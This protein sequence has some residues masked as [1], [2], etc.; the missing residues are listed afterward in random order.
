MLG[1]RPI[2]KQEPK[3][4]Q[5]QPP[6][7]TRRHSTEGMSP[8]LPVIYEHRGNNSGDSSIDRECAADTHSHHSRSS[9]DGTSTNPSLDGF[10]QNVVWP[11]LHSPSWPPRDDEPLIRRWNEYGAIETHHFDSFFSNC[12]HGDSQHHQTHPRRMDS[13][14]T[15]AHSNRRE[16]LHHNLNICRREDVHP[17]FNLFDSLNYSGDSGSNG[18]DRDGSYSFL[19]NSSFHRRHRVHTSVLRIWQTLSVLVM[20]VFCSS[21]FLMP[22]ILEQSNDGQWGGKVHGQYDHHDVKTN[23]AE[24]T[25]SNEDTKKRD[26]KEDEWSGFQPWK[27]LFGA[28]SGN[29]D[30]KNETEPNEMNSTQGNYSGAPTASSV[31]VDTTSTSAPKEP[32]EPKADQ[33][34]EMAAYL[35]NVTF[36]SLAELMLPQHLQTT[37]D[38]CK[39]TIIPYHD[40]DEKPSKSKKRAGLYNNNQNNS[41]D[42]SAATTSVQPSQVFKLRKQL[43]KTRDMI[44][45]FAPTYPPTTESKYH[46]GDLNFETRDIMYAKDNMDLILEQD[47]SF[48]KNSKVKDGEEDYRVVGRHDMFQHSHNHVKHRSYRLAK[49]KRSKQ[50]DKGKDLWRTIRKYLDEGYTVIGDF[51]DLDHAKIKYTADQ[52][53]G[54]Q[55]EVWKWHV[56]F[57]T[58][59]HRNYLIVMRYLSHPCPE[60]AED[61][62]NSRSDKKHHHGDRRRLSH[63]K[64]HHSKS[65]NSKKSKKHSEDS[66]KTPPKAIC[67]YIHPHTSHLF[68]GGATKD[69]LPIGDATL[70]HVALGQLGIRQLSRAQ[71]YLNMLWK[72]D[73]II[74]TA[75]VNEPIMKEGATKNK[76]PSTT[77]KEDKDV[78]DDI[79]SVLNSP[80]EEPTDTF[81]VHEVYHNLRKEVRSFL[82]EVN[83][84]GTLILPDTVVRPEALKL[85]AKK[86]RS[87]EEATEGSILSLDVLTSEEGG[88]DA[89]S[90]DVP[91]LNI[92]VPAKQD[93]GPQLTPPLKQ[94]SEPPPHTSIIDKL[95]MNARQRTFDALSALEQTTSLLGKLN[96]HYVA[97]ENY[98]KSDSHHGDQVRLM[99]TIQ[100][101]WN[102]FRWWAGR[103]KLNDQIEY[104]KSRMAIA[105]PINESR[106]EV[107]IQVPKH[108]GD[109][110]AEGYSE[111]DSAQEAVDVDADSAGSQS[112]ESNVA[113]QDT[114]A[115]E[116][117]Q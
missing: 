21:L 117:G 22:S 69:Q 101:E 6:A 45:V 48:H 97:Y 82:D 95:T 107:G 25:N 63:K 86:R 79:S 73:Y 76:H 92:T 104:L 56:D 84:F 11:P 9:S 58:F 35:A 38:L 105:E 93:I 68:W 78:A 27:Y 113:S 70:A 36:A 3:Q 14:A 66:P 17:N 116:S 88:P 61:E 109:E 18:G 99:D 72:K 10:G 59:M 89:N 26:D 112:E 94:N 31:S 8:P 67:Q 7:P 1:F 65:K 15:E 75:D 43:L 53:A 100:T 64:H 34:E 108:E 12:M 81:D 87:N 47:G 96:D 51:Q 28:D 19:N 40:P 98:V 20:V 114:N 103:I 115:G 39:S 33:E 49:T 90:T 29:Q 52:L 30:D 13:D 44:D 102:S 106:D 54:H 91:P 23:K 110:S 57:M 71:D 2:R 42:L 111:N 41:L 16:D 32:K 55:K 46:E 77:K 4:P 24:H 74:P 83:F 50:Y 85:M 80:E 62:H 37:I 60:N 5:A